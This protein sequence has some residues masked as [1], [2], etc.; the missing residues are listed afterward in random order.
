MEIGLLSDS[1][2]PLPS[3]GKIPGGP[4]QEGKP[5]DK[6]DSVEISDEARTKLAELADA[7]LAAESKKGMTWKDR[8]D[9]VRDRIG[10]G[11]YDR[12]SVREKI[13]ENLMDDLDN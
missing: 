9:H 11:F 8:V 12:P 5:A 1:R 2:K 10:E 7:A 3:S 6:Q 13:A 4:E